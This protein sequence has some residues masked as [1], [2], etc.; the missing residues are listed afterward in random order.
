MTEVKIDEVKGVPI[1][2]SQEKKHFTY[3]NPATKRKRN[4]KKI[5]TIINQINFGAGQEAFDEKLRNKVVW[6]K[7]F[8]SHKYTRAVLTGRVRKSNAGTDVEAV[9][10]DKTAFMRYFYFYDGDGDKY[11]EL[12]DERSEIERKIKQIGFSQIKQPS[13]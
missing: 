8:Y 10:D 12:A 3:T 7:N 9:V 13:I 1:F 6:Q 11:N 2:W 5:E 4:Y